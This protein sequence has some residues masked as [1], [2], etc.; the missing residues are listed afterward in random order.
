M[1]INYLLETQINKLT[2][3]TPNRTQRKVIAENSHNT[4]SDQPSKEDEDLSRPN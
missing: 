4:I 1:F 2:K 3:P